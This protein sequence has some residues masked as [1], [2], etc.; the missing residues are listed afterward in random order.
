M[1]KYQ[2]SKKRDFATDIIIT[3]DTYAGIHAMPYVTAVVRTPD[4][5]A[6][7]Y[8]RTIDGLTK[9]AVINNIASANPV[10]AAGCD[11]DD[12]TTISTTEQVLTLTD[13]KVNEQICR[14]TVF[15]TWMGQGMDRNGNL[16]QAF[17]DF[18]LQVV[19]GK[20]AAQLEIGIWQ[21]SSPF[22]VGFLSDDGTQDEAGAD[23]SA[24]KDFT[25]VDFADA[26]AASDIITDLN[27][28]Y[29]SAAANLPQILTKP[30]FGFYMNA[31]TYSFYC[32]ALASATTFQG[33]GAA[34]SFDAL[35][36][37]GFPIYVCP[38]MFNDVIV[39]TYPENLVFGTNNSTDW[40]EVRLIPAYEYDGSDNV[41]I[42]MN[43]AV[44]VQVAVATDGVYGSTVWS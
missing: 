42:V 32:Q 19:A 1:G 41:K 33:L 13:L 23:A 30:G 4:T 6:K 24:L 9:S 14:G 3:G 12:T 11:F 8:V 5:V 7:G 40:T 43:F 10:Q 27:S 29:A 21:G 15:P 37:M 18:L 28:V 25:E 39:A 17:S 36:Y 34:G 22:G 26:L 35:T 31:Q 2:I 38:G 16:P 44:G 20:A